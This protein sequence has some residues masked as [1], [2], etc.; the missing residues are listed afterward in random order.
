[1][2]HKI[3]Q[4]SPFWVFH[5]TML[6]E[7]LHQSLIIIMHRFLSLLSGPVN[8][9]PVHLFLGNFPFHDIYHLILLFHHC[10]GRSL[11]MWIPLWFLCQPTY[12]GFTLSPQISRYHNIE[13]GIQIFPQNRQHFHNPLILSVP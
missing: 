13:E 8:L 12:S 7:D 3:I 2:R 9:Q 10:R 6:S 11:R 5:T 4:V 1:M